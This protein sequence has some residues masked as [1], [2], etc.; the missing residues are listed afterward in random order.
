MKIGIVG[1]TGDIGEGMALRLS[2]IHEVILGSRDE[3]KACTASDC[4]IDTLRSRGVHAQCRGVSNQEAVDAGDVIVLALPFAHVESTL[5]GLSGF[6]DKIVVSPVNPIAR[7]DHFSYDP[8]AEGSA[9]VFIKN[10]L[11]KSATVVS[12]FN[13][14]AAH[15]W[16]ELDALLDYSVAVC[17][18]DADAKAIVMDLIWDIRSLT[19]LDAGPLSVSSIVESITPLVLNIAK[20]NQM[21]DVG[22]Y[23]R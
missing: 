3:A 15:K 22:V 10:R 23:F 9:A 21:R 13:N 2:H 5:A 7:S 17:S 19:P 16:K 4:T 18:D 14:I 8:P 6:E 20:N 11:P 12:A 1:G